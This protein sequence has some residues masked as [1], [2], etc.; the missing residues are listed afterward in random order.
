M[1]VLGQASNTFTRYLAAF[2]FP[3]F[4]VQMF[5]ALGNGWA[6]SLLGFVSILLIP[7]PFAF[8]RYGEHLRARSKYVPDQ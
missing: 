5:K 2:A 6:C 3:L 4:A 7:I 1:R 8:G